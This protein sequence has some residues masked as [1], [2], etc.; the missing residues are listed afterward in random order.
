L[1]F[2]LVGQQFFFSQ[3]ILGRILKEKIP[4]C[5]VLAWLHTTD[6]SNTFGTHAALFHQLIALDFPISFV[7][8]ICSFLSNR[9]AEIMFCS[10]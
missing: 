4:D 8:Y 2:I 10:W 5:T 1:A 7:V 3:F 6:L 9:W